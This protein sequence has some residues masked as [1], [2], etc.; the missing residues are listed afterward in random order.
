MALDTAVLVEGMQ[1]V[2]NSDQPLNLSLRWRQ[3]RS[4]CPFCGGSF[5]AN[6][7]TDHCNHCVD[8]CSIS[9][10]LGK[11]R[12]ER[13]DAKA[14]GVESAARARG[15]G[16]VTDTLRI[17]VSQNKI[18]FQEDGFDLDLTYITPRCIAMGFPSHGAESYYRNPIEEVERFFEARHQCPQTGRRYY[19]VYN[20]C[21]E[22]QYDRP[23]RFGQSYARY[24]FDDHNAPTP[25]SLIPQF[26]EDAR[27]WLAQDPKNIIAVHCKAGKG[28]TG[29]MVTAHLMAT[30]TSYR[31]A[32][33]ALKCFNDARTRDGKGVT[34]ASQMRYV[35]YWEIMQARYEGQ[36]PPPRRLL[37]T[38]ISVI[39]GPKT[40]G[41][42]YF[43][44]LRGPSEKGGASAEVFDS[45][46]RFHTR[47]VQ[48]DGVLDW[49]VAACGR[50]VEVYGDVKFIF[51]SGGGLLR[52]EHSFHFWI[53]TAFVQLHDRLGKSEL[54]K[55]CKDRKHLVFSKDLAVEFWFE[56][57][58][59]A[60]RGARG[61][62][63]H[64]KQKK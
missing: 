59:A 7:L 55:A 44:I 29:V 22:R 52:T 25:L 42:H 16:V 56:P 46:K 30:M 48:K 21:S 39:G 3:V 50:D 18:R 37:L 10:E 19:R 43:V 60:S 62:F 15:G 4:Q 31:S 47:Q 53:N 51:K 6:V 28:R 33:D 20:L 1:P 34:I 14:R 58:D 54:D 45:R 23:D 41:E 36:A 24:P 2:P 26:C 11:Q 5:P 49:D 38:R 12:K 8:I 13:A 32:D 63:Q 17:M 57:A 9:A 61:M 35:R 64:W 27:S 40:G